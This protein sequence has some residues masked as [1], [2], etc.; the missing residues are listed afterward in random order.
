M[1]SRRRPAA[2]RGRRCVALALR[3]RPL[4]AAA[5]DAQLSRRPAD[6]RFAGLQWRFVRIK[7]HYDDRR[8]RRP[9]LRHLRRAW[10]IDVPA[11]EQNLSRRVK[12]V[13]SIQVHDP[14]VLTLDDPSSLELSLDLHRRA[15]QPAA[16][17]TARSPILREFL[18]RGGTLTFDD[19]HGPIEWD[20]LEREMKRV[21]P[22]RE[23]VDLPQDHPIFSC[24]Y[25][26]DGYPQIAGPRL[27]PAGPHL[28]EGRLR[29]APARHRG[30]RRP[31]DGADQL[32][33]RH[34]RRLGVVERRG[35][36]RLR[37]VHRAWPTGWGSTKSSTALTH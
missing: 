34:G 17:A 24:F 15:G 32:E 31:A 8:H 30:R 10:T 14:I 16:E 9:P 4:A 28:G 23:I 3:R 35:V 19:F 6:D 26:L 25:E 27:V 37:E 1:T 5:L 22:D 7:Y 2:D 18:L 29:R 11:A 33:H 12:T 36:S 13:T 21:F 20:N